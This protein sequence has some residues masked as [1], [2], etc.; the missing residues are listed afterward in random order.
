[1]QKI[2]SALALLVL[3]AGASAQVNVEVVFEDVQFLRSESVPVRVKISNFSG[4]ALRLAEERDWIHFVVTGNDNRAMPQ[5]EPMPNLKPF[6]VE[7]GKTI[8]VRTDLAPHFDLNTAG[9]YGVSV[10][11]KFPQLQKELTTDPKHFDIISGVKIWE[12]TV[13]MP[14]TTPPV[15]RKLALQ[16]ATFVK[17]TRLFARVTDANESTVFSVIPLG[18][19]PSASKPEAAVDA[20][21]QMHILYQAGQRNFSYS[22]V[23]PDGDLIVRQ[24]HDITT[25]RPRLRRES[26]GRVVVHGG[27][28]RVSAT[29]L[30]PPPATA[31]TNAGVAR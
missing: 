11:V 7:A 3:A 2:L 29:D 16:R 31:S 14:G 27:A 19:L 5:K 25:S 6:T 1:M 22:I 9:R 20:S 21:S 17:E 30:P 8:A 24:T 13:G 28:R 26:D 12:E 10:R 15:L 4:Q 18:A 23:T